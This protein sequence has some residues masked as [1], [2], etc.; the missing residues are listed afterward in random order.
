[1]LRTIQA[2]CWTGAGAADRHIQH[3]VAA[4]CD[5]TDLG[6]DVIGKEDLLHFGERLAVPRAASNCVAREVVANWLVVREVDPVVLLVRGVQDDVHQSRLCA[7]VDHLGH[8]SHW[9]RIDRTVA[10]HAQRATTFGDEDHVVRQERESVRMR[11]AFRDNRHADLCFGRL[12]RPRAGAERR[13][14]QRFRSWWHDASQIAH[15]WIRILLLRRMWRLLTLA[16]LLS[17]NGR[18]NGDQCRRHHH[19]HAHSLPVNHPIPPYK[20]FVARRAPSI[21]AR[22]FAHTISGCP[23]RDP[24]ASSCSGRGS[25]P[26]CEVRITALLNLA[27]FEGW[28]LARSHERASGIADAVARRTTGWTNARTAARS[29][30]SGSSSC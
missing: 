29:G 5:A 21:N 25:V 17:G 7:A 2:R 13:R 3:A 15:D 28:A 1:M 9:I 11:E 8:A 24:R 4:E 6:I 20:A 27:Q 16:R 23:T 26:T 30:P 22:N 10:D 18:D 12:K 19:T 14:R